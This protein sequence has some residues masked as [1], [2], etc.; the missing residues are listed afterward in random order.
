MHF[1][2]SRG[3]HSQNFCF[4]ADHGGASSFDYMWAPSILKPHR[5]P[6]DAISDIQTANPWS[7]FLFFWSKNFLV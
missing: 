4:V 7:E 5:W 6:C 1:R 3:V 2:Q